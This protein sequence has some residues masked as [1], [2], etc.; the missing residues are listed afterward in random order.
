MMCLSSQTCKRNPPAEAT[1]NTV[2]QVPS[3]RARVTRV[4]VSWLWASSHPSTH[5]MSYAIRP[6]VTF[7][8]WHQRSQWFTA[9]TA[10]PIPR[11]FRR[12]DSFPRG[13]S[14]QTHQK[15]VLG[16]RSLNLSDLKMGLWSKR[17]WSTLVTGLGVRASEWAG[18]NQLEKNGER[19]LPSPGPAETSLQIQS[20]TSQFGHHKGK[21]CLGL[22]P[23]HQEA[24]TKYGESSQYSPWRHSIISAAGLQLVYISQQIPTQVGL[25]V[26]LILK[27]YD[28]YKGH[29]R[30]ARVTTSLKS[31]ETH[32]TVDRRLY[33][34]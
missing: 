7:Q 15:T 24:E 19:Y 6:W 2:R 1:A 16:W 34:L 12:C 32:L 3:T 33:V 4:E 31:P 26:V 8:R 22:G 28:S 17:G 13:T 21:G 20:C 25:P 23:S 9:G 30:K 14:P 29:E 5:S 27:D 10:K 18:F 11:L